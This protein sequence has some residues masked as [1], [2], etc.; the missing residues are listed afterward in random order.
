ML[1][2][3]ASQLGD[4]DPLEVIAATPAKRLWCNLGLR[5]KKSSLA[6]SI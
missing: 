5:D 2:P 6:V 1:N 3:Y 4:L